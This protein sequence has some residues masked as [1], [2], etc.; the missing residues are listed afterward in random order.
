MTQD[1]TKS[2]RG[3]TLKRVAALLCIAAVGWFAYAYATRYL[4]ERPQFDEAAWSDA[5]AV[6]VEVVG[7]DAVERGVVAIPKAKIAVPKRSFALTGIQPQP[8]ISREMIWGNFISVF[9]DG[10]RSYLTR[11][12]K[13]C[14]QAD[15]VALLDEEK[16]RHIFAVLY[17]LEKL[18]AATVTGRVNAKDSYLNRRF[19]LNDA[20]YL[21]TGAQLASDG[22]KVDTVLIAHQ[23]KAHLALSYIDDLFRSGQV[24]VT[25]SADQIRALGKALVA[26]NLPP[27]SVFGA[28]PAEDGV[29]FLTTYPDPSALTLLTR[30]QRMAE[31]AHSDGWWKHAPLVGRFYGP[32]AYACYLDGAEF[33]I[34]AAKAL[35]GRP[36]NERAQIAFNAR[37]ANRKDSYGPTCYLERAQPSEFAKLLAAKY[38]S[39]DAR[40][41]ADLMHTYY[42]C[43]G[44]D[45]RVAQAGVD[46]SDIQAR[47]LANWYVF[48]A[49]R[50]PK[51]LSTC[52]ACLV[53][54]YDVTKSNQYLLE[55]YYGPLTQAYFD[56]PTLGEI[57]TAFRSITNGVGDEQALA[58]YL[59]PAPGALER[60]LAVLLMAGGKENTDAAMRIAGAF[61]ISDFVLPNGGYFHI[62]GEPSIGYATMLAIQS[63][64]NPQ[65]ADSIIEFLKA[66]SPKLS[67]GICEAFVTGLAERGDTR[68]MEILDAAM[69]E[70]R[71]STGRKCV[72]RDTG[73]VLM[74]FAD[75]L[76]RA[77][78]TVEMRNAADPIAYLSD[79][80]TRDPALLQEAAARL[81]EERYTTVQLQALLADERCAGFRSAIC[82]AIMHEREKG[83]L[84]QWQ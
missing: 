67:S 75:F 10:P 82:L 4:A 14:P 37:E 39:Y 9:L 70:E 54:L 16:A 62:R 66:R 44:T 45:I 48:K 36:E 49:T 52:L 72:D 83:V 17:Y 56:D 28:L 46:D 84:A 60:I 58:Q 11:K 25:D 15:C 27:H 13:V 61:E 80:K 5:N 20:N 63:A 64:E 74:D 22:T 57:P 1:A 8:L 43:R 3:K 38:P 7:K 35:G 12:S 2:N 30:A 34:W 65:I 76:L 32:G 18:Q 29:D 79:T 40:T 55:R 73:S 19:H 50:D 68:L 77:R 51:A 53:G 42:F 41:R 21:G 31:R 78:M 69:K 26:H 23:L 6:L 24:R 71:S 33:A 47:F 81:L 59:Q